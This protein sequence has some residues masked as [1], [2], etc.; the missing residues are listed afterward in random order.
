MLISE[1][2][3]KAGDNVPLQVE[4]GQVKSVYITCQV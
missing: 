3:V 1:L 2:K 4:L